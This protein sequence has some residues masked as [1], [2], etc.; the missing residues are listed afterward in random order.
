MAERPTPSPRRHLRQTLKGLDGKWVAV[1][2]D[3]IVLAH[4]SP[5][6][7]AAELRRRGIRDVS[8][9]RAPGTDEPEMVAFG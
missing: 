5:Y 3:E 6:E 4:E 9:I 1:R 7:L 8:I 2:G